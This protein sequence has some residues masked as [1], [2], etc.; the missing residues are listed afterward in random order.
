MLTVLRELEAHADH[1][2]LPQA[3]GWVDLQFEIRILE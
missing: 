1:A 2:G 3:M